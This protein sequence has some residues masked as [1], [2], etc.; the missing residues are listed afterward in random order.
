MQAGFDL[1]G[2]LLEAAIAAGKAVA[3]ILATALQQGFLIFRR[4]LHALLQKLGPLGDVFDWLLT[5]ASNVASLAWR[6]AINA[7][8]MFGRS[9]SEVLNWAKNKSMDVL[10]QVVNAIDSAGMVIAD[11]IAWAKNAGDAALKAVGEALYK[12]GRTV[13]SIMI[14]IEK[15]VIAGVRAIVAGLL[16]AGATVAELMVWAVKR[17]LQVVKDVVTEMIAAGVTLAQIVADTIAHPQN[18]LKNVVQ[19]FNELGQTLKDIVNA[20]IIQPTEDAARRVLQALKDL[21]KAAKDVMIAALEL[22]GSA[23]ALTF[24]LLLEWFPGV[25]RPLTAG[26]RAEAVKVFGTAI[27]LDKVRLSVK[28]LPV[29]L[30]QLCNDERPFTTMYLINFASWEKLSPATLIHEL[31]HVW[32]GVTAGPIYMVEAIE[33]QLSSEG[34]NYGYDDGTTGEGAQPEL[35][36]AGGNFNSFNR[37]QQGQIVMHYYTRRYLNGL[38]YSAWQ[39]YA[40]AVH[41]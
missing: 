40:N 7:M 18:A 30:I 12:V 37:E 14:W 28:S 39:P 17:S 34:Y 35:A 27:D 24:A 9:V 29:D 23:I 41:A 15:D 10:K 32:Q 8:Q 22:G 16:K 36:A 11:V 1:A 3:S 4:T 25:Y 13:E 38:D 20:A 2:K 26:E 5:Q 19:A 31:V 21:G 6:E 33:S